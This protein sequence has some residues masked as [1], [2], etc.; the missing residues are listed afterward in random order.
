MAEL[1]ISGAEWDV[2]E[3]VWE[4]NEATAAEVIARLA[5]VK[6]WNHRT[7]R[8]LLARLVDKRALRA[9]AVGNRYVYTAAITRR[10]CVRRESRSFLNKVFGGDTG[11]LL[12]HFVRDPHVNRDDLAQ[13]RQLLDQRLDET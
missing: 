8:T 9:E 4:R 2:M 1:K 6:E 13:L 12:A 7:V 5:H 3:I 11:S 10:Q